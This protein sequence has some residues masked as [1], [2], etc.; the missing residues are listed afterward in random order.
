MLVISIGV[1]MMAAAFALSAFFRDDNNE[2]EWFIPVLRILAFGG[3]A[4][5]SLG[6]LGKLIVYLTH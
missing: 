2:P 6:L 3:S 1:L 5:I 4:A